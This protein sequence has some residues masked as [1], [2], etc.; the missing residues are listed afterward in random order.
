MHRSAGREPV[1]PLWAVGRGFVEPWERVFAW[2]NA[3]GQHARGD[4][5]GEAIPSRESAPDVRLG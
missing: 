4:A 5:A 1:W 3:L 2:L